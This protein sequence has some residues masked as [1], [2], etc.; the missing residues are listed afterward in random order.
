MVT[1]PQLLRSRACVLPLPKG[2]GRGE[3]KVTL[4]KPMRLRTGEEHNY[5][6][7]M[8]PPR[9]T[10]VARVLRKHDTWAEKLIWNSLR[11]RRFSEYKLC[12]QHPF[13]PSVLGSCKP[14]SPSPWPSPAGRGNSATRASTSPA[15]LDWR[16]RGRG[17][18]ERGCVRRTSRSR[19]EDEDVLKQS[20]A[21]R[22]AM[23]LRLGFAHSRGPAVGGGR[24]TGWGS[25]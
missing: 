24:R 4:E 22:P 6:R 12:Q 16:K 15:A 18:T 10:R 5:A 9:L 21:L 17:S 20:S 3:G 19:T 11:D 2:E 8:T 1:V 13:G 23:T 25:S 14:P 7:R